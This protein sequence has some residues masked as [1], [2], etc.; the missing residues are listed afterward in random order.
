M[1]IGLVRRFFRK[2]PLIAM[3][4]YASRCIATSFRSGL[5]LFVLLGVGVLQVR[6]Q[7]LS[8]GD[9]LPVANK[10][11]PRAEGGTATLASLAGRTGTVVIFWSNQCPWTE[12]YEERLFAI[13]RQYAD[14]GISFVLINSNNATAFPEE[15]LEAMAEANYDMPYLRDKGGEVAKAFGAERT[16]HVFVF[17]AERTLVYSGAI[18]DSAVDPSA[19][20]ETY[21]ADVLSA[22]VQGQPVPV[23]QTEAF[24]CMIRF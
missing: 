16:P 8:P 6:A 15:S 22:L 13:H 7:E 9:P 24:G 12:R 17:D 20:E 3:K 23:K 14:E 5:V 4:R 21:L 10:P 18:D 2:S 11:L 1:H 19:V